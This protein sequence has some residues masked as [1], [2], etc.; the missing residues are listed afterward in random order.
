MAP[1]S[2]TKGEFGSLI[3]KNTSFSS[4]GRKRSRIGFYS[5]VFSGSLFL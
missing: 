2:F 3:V 1:A 5:V 4:K